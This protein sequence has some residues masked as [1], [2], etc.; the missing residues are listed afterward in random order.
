MGFTDRERFQIGSLESV[1]EAKRSRE[2]GDIDNQSICATRWT[3]DRVT[4]LHYLVAEKKIRQISQRV[5]VSAILFAAVDL[6]TH[7]DKLSE[8]IQSDAYR[9]SRLASVWLSPTVSLS[10]QSALWK[11][12]HNFSPQNN[13][14]HVKVIPRLGVSYSNENKLGRQSSPPLNSA[15]DNKERVTSGREL[16]SIRPEVD[17]T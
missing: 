9:V 12:Y 15:W 17:P 3:L 16:I 7:G 13:G 1:T 2:D 10:L 4:R 14:A 8:F 5:T 11:F 6:F